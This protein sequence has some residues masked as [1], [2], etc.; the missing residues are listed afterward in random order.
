MNTK[1]KIKNIYVRECSEYRELNRFA[2]GNGVVLFG[3]S[4]A[5]SIPVGKLG[6][7]C[8]LDN[9]VYNRSITDLSVFDAENLL[10]DCVISLA[11]KKVILHLGETD[12]AKGYRSISEIVRAY[13]SLID[14]VKSEIKRCEIVIVSVCSN[15]D[16][17]HPDDLNRQ[18]ETLAKNK[19]CKYV[20]ITGSTKNEYP[21]AKAFSMLKMYMSD[22]L[23]FYDAMTMVNYIT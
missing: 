17:I 20:D 23:S 3:S 13:E 5:K 10:D 8:S 1:E 16:D 11:P 18:L 2:K 12:L 6:Q 22:K 7:S 9:Y 15:G 4:F 14:K 19:K 21:F